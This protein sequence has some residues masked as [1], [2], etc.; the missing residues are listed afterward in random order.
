MRIVKSATSFAVALL[1]I[2][3]GGTGSEESPEIATT[4]AALTSGVSNGCTFTLSYRE[5][6]TS[7]P[8]LYEAVVTRHSA[9]KQ[10][11][12]WGNGSV[13]LGASYSVPALSLAANEHGVAASFTYKHSPSGSASTNLQL[14]HVAPNTLA[15]VRSET[16]RA[17]YY[18]SSANVHGGELS[19]LSDGTTLEVRGT[20]DGFIPGESGSGPNYI[21]TYPDFF[22]ST[23]AP[24]IVAY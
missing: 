10:K 15:V 17:E 22:T 3:C 5:N 20:K 8:P 2:A 7:F 21:A 9:H 13:V 23:A 19:I 4:S 1:L 18:F 16:I 6:I 12:P 24:S 14:R 11:C